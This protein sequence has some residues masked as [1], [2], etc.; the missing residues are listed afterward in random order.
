MASALVLPAIAFCCANVTLKDWPCPGYWG[1]V[2]A[3]G[4]EPIL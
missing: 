3:P 1:A 4:R 2:A